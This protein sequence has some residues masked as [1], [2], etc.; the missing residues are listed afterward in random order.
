MQTLT[1]IRGLPG[2]GKSTQAAKLPAQP[3]FEADQFF[4]VDGVYK[5]DPSKLPQAHAEC[6][7][8]TRET[9]AAGDSCIVANTFTQRWEMETYLEMAKEF[10]TRLNVVDLFDGDC[11]DEELAERNIHGVPLQAIQAMRKRY[12]L[13]WWNGSTKRPF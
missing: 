8:N 12:Q 11:S 13:D 10:D 4:V 1:L 3:I 5:F 2:C 6:Q 7:K 9:L